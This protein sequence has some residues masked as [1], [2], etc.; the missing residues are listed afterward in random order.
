MSAV[1]LSLLLSAAIAAFLYIVIPGPAFLAL[2]G[3][4]AGQG[5]MA[6]GKFMAGHLAGDILWTTLALV[7]I[8][9]AR[10]VGETVFDVLG[11]FCG[12]YLAF[13]GWNAFRARPREAGAP[14]ITVERPFR[15]GLIF[16]LTN[17]KGYPVALATY[18]ALIGGSSRLLSFGSLPELLGAALVGFL[19]G[20]VIIIA[21]IG[22]PLVRRFY[23]AHELGIVRASGLLFMGFAAEAIWHAAPGLI[24]NRRV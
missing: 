21:V 7:A 4:G 2:L 14:V 18:T 5:R 11:L 16:G 15:R 19:A 8:V 23:R 3:I 24:G 13:I 20:Y 17:P 22:A 10:V 6:G 12:G 1:P 9:G